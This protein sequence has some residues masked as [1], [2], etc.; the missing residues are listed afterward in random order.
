[1]YRAFIKRTLFMA[2][3]FVENYSA[4]KISAVLK[5]AKIAGLR[6]VA[7][8]VPMVAGVTVSQ[9]SPG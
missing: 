2:F 3:Q 4:R 7:A 8:S 5:L 9:T 1:M 6:F